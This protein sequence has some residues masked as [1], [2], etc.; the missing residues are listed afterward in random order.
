MKFVAGLVLLVIG[1]FFYAGLTG[2]VDRARSGFHRRFTSS[3][4]NSTDPKLF[5][6]GLGA[7]ALIVVL[8]VG[9]VRR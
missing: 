6:I 9:G 2:D 5:A 1:A 3:S 8:G 4:K 7:G